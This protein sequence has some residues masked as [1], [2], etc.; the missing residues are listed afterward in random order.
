ML[1]MTLNTFIGVAAVVLDLAFVWATKTA[2]DIAT[3]RST[4]S[5]T[6][7]QTFMLLAAFMIGRIVL[8]VSAS[9]ISA[10]L[11]V[12]ASNAMR[13]HVYAQL[14]HGDWLSLR[15]FHTG[16]IMNR[17]ETDVSAVVSFVTE[18]LPSLIT[19]IAQFLGAFFFLFYMDSMLACVVVLVLPF[20]I[21]ASKLYVK[22]LKALTHEVRN[23]DSRI[24]SMLQE[25]L[26]HAMV[27]KT[28]MRTSYFTERLNTLQ[29]T[30]HSKVLHRAKFSTF[31][32]GI[33]TLG[34]ATDYLIA[35]IWGTTNLEKGAITYGAMIAFIQLV[36]KVQAPVQSLT[37]FVPLFI[38]TAT[39]TERLMDLNDIPQETQAKLTRM[40]SPLGIRF[41]HVN[42]SYT[43]ESRQILQDFNYEFRPG[44]VTAIVGETGAGKTT[45]VKMLFSLVSPQSGRVRIYDSKGQEADITASERVRFCY[46]PQG[47]SLFSGTI[48]SNLL[49]GNPDAT[50]KEMYDALQ[51]AEANFVKESPQGLDTPCGETGDGLSEGQAQRIAIARA[52]LS[53]GPILVLDEATSALDAQTEKNVLENLS[54]HFKQK[55]I[56]FITHRSEVLNHAAETLKMQRLNRKS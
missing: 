9:W 55:T 47:N 23:E 48:R 14:M 37:K 29:G 22:K 45:L 26:Q 56:I 10:I 21:L 33:T 52:L 8:S 17:I 4:S 53:N 35:F 11:G 38:R 25:T 49:L 27:V 30:L 50:E 42:F 40:E 44:T 16:D 32:S 51:V 19:T 24:Q 7:N 39:S 31:S 1:Q 54:A 12:K 18:S 15:K 28:L 3:H 41:S 13:R 36:N 43:P 5:L 2:V 6:L 20:F 34:F 46:V